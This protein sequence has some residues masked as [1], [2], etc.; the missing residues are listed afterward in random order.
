MGKPT[1]LVTGGGAG[2]GEGI[3]QVL[4]QRGWHVLVN[5]IDAP[6]A[7]RVAQAVGG[8]ALPGDIRTDPGALIS[9]AVAVSG[10]L[11]AL[12]N[13]AGIIRRSALADTSEAD[14]DLVYEVNLKGMVRL[15]QAALPH[16]QQ[17]GGAMV[18]ISS[19]AAENPQPG[20]GFYSMSKA[21]VSAFTRHAAQEWGPLGVRVNAVAPGLIR[22]AMAEAVYSV[23]E[24]HEKRRMMMPLRRIGTPI[25]LGK[26]V[27][28]LLSDD[29][30]YVSG[31]IIAVDGGFSQTLI[32][33]LPH[34]PTPTA[35]GRAAGG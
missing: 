26:V 30:S 7:L 5:D 23:P 20:A 12:V 22:T 24:L 10:A 11:H 6:A 16:L 8:T 4:A 21:G 32:S 1:V 34:P 13:N 2:I 15:A 27:A 28:F 31:Q 3:S 25:E 33:H 14:L 17:T 9:S 29:A 19:I 35:Q 18:N